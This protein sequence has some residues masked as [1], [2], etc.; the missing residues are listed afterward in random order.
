MEK[1]VRRLTL[2]KSERLFERKAIE[3]V[4]NKGRSIKEH[5]I[6]LL[7]LTRTPI[8]NIPVKAAFTVSSRNFK[9]AVDRNLIKRRMREAYRKNKAGVFEPFS[10]KKLECLIMFIYVDNKIA[11]YAEIESKIIVALQRL[12]Q[13]AGGK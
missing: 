5:P 12:I 11:E 10:E 8:G 13:H 2:R 4:F 3:E 1:S 9:R 7:W 6:R